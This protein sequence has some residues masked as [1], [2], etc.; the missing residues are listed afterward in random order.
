[1]A[2]TPSAMLAA[3]ANPNDRDS[4]PHSTQSGHP[5]N[6]PVCGRALVQDM[7]GYWHC[8]DTSDEHDEREWAR[9]HRRGL[10]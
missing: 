5:G 4:S 7:G 9:D 1:M 3:M 10:R 8:P 6:C 2:Y